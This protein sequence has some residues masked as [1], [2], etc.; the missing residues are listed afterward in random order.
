MPT[1]KIEA[2]RR[3]SF[4]ATFDDET[5]R[6]VAEAMHEVAYSDGEAII[7][8]GERGRNLSVLISGRA[9]VRV[10]TEGA[11]LTTVSVMKAGDSF[12]EMSLLSEDPTSADVVAVEDCETLALSREAFHRLISDHPV[13]LREFVRLLS[14]RVR[15][16]TASFA[17]ARQKEEDL[18]SLLRDQK[19]EQYAALIGA[20]KPMKELQKQI[21][22]RS[23]TRTPL[24]I[25]GEKGAGKELIARLVHLRGPGKDAPL[26]SLEC[27]QIT[28]SQWGDQLFGLYDAGAAAHARVS[29]Y[30]ALGDGGTILLKNVQGLPPALQER[31]VRFLNG[32]ALPN[33]ARPSVRVIATCRTNLL[34]ETA[35]GRFSPELASVLLGDVVEVPPLREH[36]RD[37]PELAAHFVRRHAQ[38]LGRPVTG[39][40]DQAMTRLV[41]YDYMFANVQEMEEAIE[42]AVIITEGD[43]ISADAI[44]LG[45][46]P[47]D[48]PRGFNLLSLPKPLVQTALRFF[49]HG[50]RAIA[51][52]AFAFILFEC[53]VVAGGPAGNLGTLLVWSVW[54]PA[55]TLSFFFAGRAWC[56]VCPMAVSGEFAQ[57][58]ARRWRKAEPRVPTWLKTHDMT[59]VTAGFFLIIWVEELTGMRRSPVATGF[60]LLAIISGALI[61]GVFLPRR[62]WCRHL[63]PM[64]GFAGLCATSSWVELRPTH[65]ICAAKCKGHSCYTGTE[66]VP[67]CPMSQ[68]AMF[69]NSNRD[70]V[71]CLNC[72]RLC[73]NGSPQLNIR[74]PARELW[75]RVS[76]RPEV[77]RLVM[78]LLGLLVGQ[79]LIQ[80]WESPAAASGLGAALLEHHRKAA[81]TVVLGLGAMLPLGFLG[82]AARRS[83][84]ASDPVS[85]ALSWQR[86]ISWAPLLGAGYTAYQFGNIPGLD[87][88]RG[89][90][91][92]LA[93]SGLSEPLLSIGVL[94]LLQ[95]VTVAAGLAITV[96]ALWKIWPPD[97]SERSFHWYQ[98]QTLSVGSAALYAL[99]LIFVMVVRSPWIM[100]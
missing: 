50:V 64:G 77:A 5:L 97:S 37:I 6:V 73:P 82:L 93:I 27:V 53:F 90:L 26:V 9:E 69:V 71:L 54:W 28:E 32:E 57:R 83:G 43:T 49:P 79:A 66:H 85:Q 1:D 36:K 59:I 45:P 41:S 86:V 3:L 24:L 11:A 39:L 55:L 87:R 95:V 60:L 51:A 94:H 13:L 63:C 25:R 80:F 72:V 74:V 16:S 78:V 76:S 34:E 88:L 89:S 2:L 4:W 48:R 38:R 21:D 46:P 84:P 15:K 31:L 75:T 68:H 22:A 98:G 20:S 14:S 67:G 44:F 10:P 8:C 100:I 30:L 12:G 19:S 7:R 65:D 40:D 35:A 23:R 56:A 52:L 96:L 70:C 58:L 92:G 42:R 17:A 62:S 33:G 81:V 18:T 99:V 47:T 29:S 61:A 91:E